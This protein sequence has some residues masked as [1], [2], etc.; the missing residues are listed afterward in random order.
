MFTQRVYEDT[1][2]S[3]LF[4]FLTRHKIDT[5]T[6]CSY[7]TRPWHFRLTCQPCILQIFHFFGFVFLRSSTLCVIIT[8]GN[9]LVWISRHE[10]WDWY[11]THRFWC[12]WIIRDFLHVQMVQWHVIELFTYFSR[13]HWWCGDK[14]SNLISWSCV[15]QGVTDDPNT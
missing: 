14:Y 10:L 1:R 9:Y 8:L 2:V 13:P 3:F 11:I 12:Q 7:E 6:C 5:F 15:Q 4:N